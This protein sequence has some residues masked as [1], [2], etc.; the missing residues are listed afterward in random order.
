VA[1]KP[2]LNPCQAMLLQQSKRSGGDG[3]AAAAIAAATQQ[4]HKGGRSERSSSSRSRVK[5]QA[6]ESFE[7][8]NETSLRHWESGESVPEGVGVGGSPMANPVERRK[9]VSRKKNPPPS[10]GILMGASGSE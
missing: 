4:S 8:G 6:N 2:Q 1:V 9:A 10:Y 7:N 3:A 5:R